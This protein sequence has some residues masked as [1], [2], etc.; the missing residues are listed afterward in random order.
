MN[1]VVMCVG[2]RHGGDDAVG[3]YIYDKLK[4]WKS[5]DFIILD[6]GTV[7]E[8]FTSVVKKQKPKRLILIDAVDMNLDPGEIRIIPMEKIAKMHVSTHNIPL[9]ILMSYL[10]QYVSNIVMIGIQPQQFSKKM[11]NQIGKAANKIIQQLKKDDID[12]LKVLS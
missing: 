8:N 6:C 10:G 2:N 4:N 7:P 11:G 9:H 5:D 12:S 3:P 1:N